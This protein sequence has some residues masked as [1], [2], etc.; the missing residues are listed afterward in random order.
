MVAACA[1]AGLPAPEFAELGFR[2][3]VTLRT[4][5][6]AEPALDR[7][8]DRILAFVRSG[9]GRSTA[10]IAKH[11]GISTRATQH[12]LAALAER[13]LI[14]VVG[15]GPRDPRRRWFAARTEGRP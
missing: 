4:E 10:E 9:A 13:G 1:A 7:V 11:A 5:R 3:R 8:E 15:S 12:R 14:V 2:F 6:V